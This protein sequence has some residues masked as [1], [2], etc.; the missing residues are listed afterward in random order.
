[1][2]A[3]GGESHH[4]VEI[5]AAEGAQMAAQTQIALGQRWLGEEGNGGGD[6]GRGDGE[7]RARGKEPR[8]SGRGET[9][10]KDGAQETPGEFGRLA[11]GLDAVAALR[12]VRDEAA[13][14]VTIAEQRNLFEKA[15]AEPAFEFAPKAEE[16]GFERE[17]EKEHAGQKRDCQTGGAQ[18]LSTDVQFLADIEQPAEQQ[19]F[20]DYSYGSG[21]H[22]EE[23]GAGRNP[24]L[25]SH[26]APHLG[27][28]AYPFLIERGFEFARARGGR[29]FLEAAGDIYEHRSAHADRFV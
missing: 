26:Q 2:R 29:G 5:E 8:D 15:E 1:V 10:L 6:D 24:T 19:S 9:H 12:H 21:C 28:G 22:S 16:R 14:E 25:R 18:P 11:D 4:G 17:F 23:R 13:A 3:N 20:D 27:Q 7:G